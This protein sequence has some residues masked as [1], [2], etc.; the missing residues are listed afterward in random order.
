MVG[1]P[2][3]ERN[4]EDMYRPNRLDRIPACDGQTDRLTDKP[5]DILPR[6]SPRYTYASRVKNSPIKSNDK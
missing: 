2:D 3:G 4:F 6:N 5:T 1:L